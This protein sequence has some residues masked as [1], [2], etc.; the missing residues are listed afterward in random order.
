MSVMNGRLQTPQG[1]PKSLVFDLPASMINATKLENRI[2]PYGQSTFSNAGQIIKF[3]IPRTDRAF[4]N[5]QTMYFTGNVSITLPGSTVGT[6]PVYMIG[7]YYSMFSRQVVSS[8]GKVLETIER[9]GELVNML[10]NMTLNPAE[11]KGL[12]NSLGFFNDTTVSLNVGEGDSTSNFCQPMNYVATPTETGLFGSSGLNFTFAIPLVGILNCA[13][14]L[15]LI[16]GDIT[17]EF[18]LNTI[19]NILAGNSAGGTT[20]IGAATI[21]LTNCELVL[22]QLNLTPES[23]AMVMAAYPEKLHIKS[24][25]YDFGSASLASGTSG[26]LDIGVNVKRSSLK[27]VLTY[28]SDA[29][30]TDKSFGGANPNGTDLVFITNGTQYPQRPIKLSNPSECYNQVQK[31]MGS[32]Y[33]NNHSGSCG[34]A[35]FCRRM[36]ANDNYLVSTTNI[37]NVPYYSNKFYLAIDTELVNYDSDSLYSGIPMGVNSNFRLN[38]GTALPRACTQYYWMVYDAVIEMDLV[39]GITNIIA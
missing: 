9:P 22:D 15:P 26:A 17:V 19:A 36:T 8:N 38:I 20:G 28:F 21:S 10:L 30:G 37:A 16:N 3:V 14:F 18:T 12:A 23:Y 5:T 6:D 1:A 4:I 25:S 11:K 2:Q 31:S 24:Q 39:N 7:S 32:L 35:E 29:S 34:K 33:S 13:K 27:Q